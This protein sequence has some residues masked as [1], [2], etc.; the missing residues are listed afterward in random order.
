MTRSARS[1]SGIPDNA[2]C[3]KAEGVSAP[4]SAQPAGKKQGAVSKVKEWA[5]KNPGKAFLVRLGISAG[6]YAGAQ[7]LGRATLNR[8]AEDYLQ[9]NFGVSKEEARRARKTTQETYRKQGPRAAEDYFNNWQQ[10]AQAEQ[11]ARKKKE[12]D[13]DKDW[14]KTL[15]VNPNASPAEIKAAFRKK[16]RESHPDLGGKSEDFQKVQKAWQSAQTLGKVRRGDS[17]E[18]K[19]FINR[20]DAEFAMA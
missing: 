12:A 13:T 14:H 7:A 20:L 11:Q 1:A 2:K 8:H 9:K 4:Q 15:G 19:W 16:A 6:I 3:T 10:E 18:M 17:I 5:K